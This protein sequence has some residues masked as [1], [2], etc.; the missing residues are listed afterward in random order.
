MDDTY[1]LTFYEVDGLVTT[2]V[3]GIR[4]ERG[5][6]N[7]TLPSD[8]DTPSS[9]FDFASFL[10]IWTLHWYLIAACGICTVLS[11]LDGNDA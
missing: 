6:E 2:M 11:S 1:L 10:V 9:H 3:G 7:M 4:F 8:H 5:Y